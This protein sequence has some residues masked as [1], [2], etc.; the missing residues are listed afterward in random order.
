MSDAIKW[1]GWGEVQKSGTGDWTDLAIN[2]D[3]NAGSAAIS[4]DEVIAI[5]FGVKLVEDNTGAINGNVTVAILR[6]DGTTDEDAPG[7]AGSQ[8]GSPYKFTITPVQSDTVYVQ[9]AIESMYFGSSVKLWIVNESGQQ[10]V[11]SVRYQTATW[12]AVGA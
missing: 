10:L 5:N 4:L 6:G 12:A 1:S 3:A 2:D 8:V 7:L 9:F 11:T